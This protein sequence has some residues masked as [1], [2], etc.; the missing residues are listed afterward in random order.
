MALILLLV[1]FNKI[2]AIYMFAMW[3]VGTGHR[4]RWSITGS[5]QFR[6]RRV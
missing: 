4:W 1:D 2:L 3:S 5:S 6:E